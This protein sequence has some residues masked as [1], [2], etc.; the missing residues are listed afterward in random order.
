MP[1]AVRVAYGSNI[2]ISTQHI[3]AVA[4]PS[5]DKSAAVPQADA[6]F[7]RRHLVREVLRRDG[8]EIASGTRIVRH[9]ACDR[10]YSQ[11]ALKLPLKLPRHS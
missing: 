8:N 9:D 10:L 2:R 7:P 11:I 3:F 6:Y 4:A 1:R 5:V